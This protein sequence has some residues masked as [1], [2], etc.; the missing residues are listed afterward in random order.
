M[1]TYLILVTGFIFLILVSCS[2]NS[3]NTDAKKVA[4]DRWLEMWNTANMTI[5]G[6]IFTADFTSHIPQYPQLTNLKSYKEEIART[7]TQV[8]D[9]QAT[10][11][12]LIVDGDKVAGRFTATGTYQGEMMGVPVND[13]E[14]TNTWIIIYHF[15]KNRIAEEWWQFDVLGVLQQIGVIPPVQEGP[16]ALRRT[17]PEDFAWSAPSLI[18][19]NPG[20]PQVNTELV[21]SEYLAWNQHDPDFFISRMDEIFSPEFV[22]HDP[23][24]PHVTDL[25]SYK[26]FAI[27]EVMNPFPDFTLTPEDTFAQNDKVVVRWTFKGTFVPLEKEIV[28]TGHTI[29]RIADGKIVEAWCDFDMM[30]TI[31]QMGA[32][33][34][35]K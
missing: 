12:D 17:E 34:G 18:T 19:G 23:A 16:P 31:Q 1:K 32:L 24:R 5:A 22:Y 20:N 29:S 7:A 6:E 14:Y 10:L 27:E 21:M 30:G 3:D 15:K 11:E 26:Q 13:K 9:F 28:Q 4:I 33:H 8:P 2:V 25:E 35:A